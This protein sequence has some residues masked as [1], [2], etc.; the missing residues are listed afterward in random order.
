[1]GWMDMIVKLA[2]LILIVSAAL[3]V[4]WDDYQQKKFE[5]REDEREAEREARRAKRHQK[6]IS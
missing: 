6:K 1:M 5:K 2:F 3:S 4:L